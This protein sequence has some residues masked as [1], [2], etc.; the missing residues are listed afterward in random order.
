LKPPL[1]WSG[2]GR[3]GGDRI[4][5]AEGKLT[6]EKKFPLPQ[7]PTGHD[8]F[9][10]RK[11]AKLLVSNNEALFLFEIS[12]EKFE[13]V[14]DLKGIKSFASEYIVDNFLPI[15]FDLVATRI[16]GS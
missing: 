4:K 9:P 6:I 5:F 14:S 15:S 2:R 13:L 3:K 11:E 12:T 16:I 10:L 1:G 7:S 8:L